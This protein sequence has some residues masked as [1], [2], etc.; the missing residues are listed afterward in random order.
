MDGSAA[1]AASQALRALAE[2]RDALADSE[3]ACSSA[4][5]ELRESNE[6]RARLSGALEAAHRG[7][8]VTCVC[9]R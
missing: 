3:A 6:A 5:T 8:C 2:A 9:T 4:R 7:A 1:A